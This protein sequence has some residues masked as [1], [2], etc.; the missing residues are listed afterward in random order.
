MS[1]RL[2][3]L[4]VFL[5]LVGAAL[6]ENARGAAEDYS[7][8]YSFVRDGEFLQITIEDNEAVTGFIS[9]F[10]DTENDKGTFLDQ[11]FKSG[12]LEGN[13]VS[14]TTEVIHGSWYKFE[15]AFA[16]GR[17]KSPEEEGYYLL[18]GTLTRWSEGAD[19][20]T[21]SQ[22]RQVEFSSFPRDTSPP[23]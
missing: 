1:A 13:K 17:G 22:Q 11:F 5:A 2:S 12:K 10:G 20:K 23:K 14:F 4:L 16:R 6:A 21:A 8:M 7:G 18:R 9:R 3:L 15:G 19:H